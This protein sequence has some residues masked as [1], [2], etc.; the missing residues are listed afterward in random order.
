MTASFCA[1]AALL[2]PRRHGDSSFRC[3]GG[4]GWCTNFPRGLTGFRDAVC[5]NNGWGAIR[6]PQGIL[7]I[8]GGNGKT[9]ARDYASCP[10]GSL[11]CGS[12]Y[13]FLA[14]NAI[15][16]ICGLHDAGYI[17]CFGGLHEWRRN[18]GVYQPTSPSGQPFVSLVGTM[19]AMAAL[20]SDGEIVAWGN[21]LRGGYCDRAIPT[22]YWWACRPYPKDKGYIARACSP[23]PPPML[24][25]HPNMRQGT[26]T[27]ECTY[28][29]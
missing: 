3:W 24:I 25:A 6:D 9:R 19:Y 14:A 23:P 12:G 29:G 17:K 4:G 21:P 16:S 20:T 2:C 22:G 5:S 18:W 13:R 28:D 7:H 1:T 10:G 8:W 15:G 11:G 26:C 27:R